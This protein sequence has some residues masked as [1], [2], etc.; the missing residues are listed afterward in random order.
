ME[1]DNNNNNNNCKTAQNAHETAHLKVPEDMEAY[2]QSMAG[3]GLGANNLAKL[4]IVQKLSWLLPMVQGSEGNIPQPETQEYKNLL[5]RITS[6]LGEGSEDSLFSSPFST[7]DKI[8]LSIFMSTS[9]F[10]H[11]HREEWENLYNDYDGDDLVMDFNSS[12]ALVEYPELYYYHDTLYGS[13]P[14]NQPSL[15]AWK[16][17]L[18]FMARQVISSLSSEK[19]SNMSNLDKRKSFQFAYDY[20]NFKLLESFKAKCEQTHPEWIHCPCRKLTLNFQNPL[21]DHGHFNGDKCDSKLCTY[22]HDRG[23][24]HPRNCYLDFVNEDWDM[25]HMLM[26]NSEEVGNWGSYPEHELVQNSDYAALPEWV[27]RTCIEMWDQLNSSDESKDLK[28]PPFGQGHGNDYYQSPECLHSVFGDARLA[29]LAQSF[30]EADDYT[31][32]VAKLFYLVL[33]EKMTDKELLRQQFLHILLSI[34][35]SLVDQYKYTA[36]LLFLQCFEFKEATNK[37]PENKGFMGSRLL[38]RRLRVFFNRSSGRTILPDSRRNIAIYTCFQGFKKGLLPIRTGK[39]LSTVL[40]H[41]EALSRFPK[42]L[43][44]SLEDCVRRTTR[45]LFSRMEDVHSTFS[46]A[47]K[48]P[49]RSTIES[50]CAQGGCL[51]MLLHIDEES[52]GGLCR[53]NLL[54][55]YL[56]IGV[57]I[58]EVRGPWIIADALWELGGTVAWRNFITEPEAEPVVILEPMKARMITK[59]DWTRYLGLKDVQQKWWNHLAHGPHRDI[60]ELIGKPVSTETVVELLKNYDPE[61]EGLNSGDFSQATDNLNS[62]VSRIILEELSFHHDGNIAMFA[63]QCES[64]ML[65]TRIW[66]HTQDLIPADGFVRTV[67]SH[68]FVL[69]SHMETWRRVMREDPEASI[70]LTPEGAD[71]LSALG[72]FVNYGVEYRIQQRDFLDSIPRSKFLDWVASWSIMQRNGQLMGSIISFVVLCVANYASYRHARETYV[73]HVIS[74]EDMKLNHP[75]KINGDDILFPCTPAFLEHWSNV[76][77]LFGFTPSPGKNLFHENFAQINSVLF[78]IEPNFYEKH[79]RSPVYTGFAEHKV[80]VVPYVNFGLITNR[81]KQ[82]CDRDP[83]V[84]KTTDQE[85]MDNTL[86]GRIKTVRSCQDKLIQYLP[87]GPL[88]DRAN[89]LFLI[90]QVAWI[91]KLLP[92]VDPF[93]S[94]ED[95][96]FGL[97]PRGY[98]PRTEKLFEGSWSLGYDPQSYQFKPPNKFEERVRAQLQRFCRSRG[99]TLPELLIENS[100]GDET[101]HLIMEH[102]GN[103]FPQLRMISSEQRFI[104]GE[105][106]VTNRYWRILKD[107]SP[108]LLRLTEGIEEVPV[109]QKVRKSIFS[110]RAVRFDSR[111]L[112]P[113]KVKESILFPWMRYDW[114]PTQNGRKLPWDVE[115]EENLID[116][117]TPFELMEYQPDWETSDLVERPL[118]QLGLQHMICV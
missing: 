105:R 28:K 42:T 102:C 98:V 33:G 65:N 17:A 14:I 32:Q 86:L 71:N 31:R 73:N 55:G 93:R 18:R 6:V 97:D 53:D 52:R 34:F 45:E 24:A 78:K 47:T 59:P 92:G 62:R 27:D 66:Y 36:N 99:K 57:R 13:S 111:S 1:I 64:A 10:A 109:E 114:Y 5:G 95:G 39:V 94:P 83:I 117:E 8:Y 112:R 37:P 40:S 100:E 81:R 26:E 60:F 106:S 35:G 115:N 44:P 88:K 46:S 48:I 87:E 74:L 16:C 2:I 82:D 15:F 29:Y 96:G 21:F 89:N 22:V 108:C 3:P 63:K 110:P 75:V 113:I 79:K 49:L 76:V 19:I 72:H 12:V 7:S 104:L 50:S 41:A 68:P 56:S 80:D 103:L 116:L 11:K 107:K 25:L 54:F 85:Y 77:R 43:E 20:T 91:E 51:G 9:S 23:A 84:F 101:L 67:A 58:I 30:R 70:V 38:P 118:P 69:K 61:S 4:F 90:H